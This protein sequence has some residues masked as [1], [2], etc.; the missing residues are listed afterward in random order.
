MRCSGH[1]SSHQSAQSGSNETIQDL[2]SLPALYPVSLDILF[3]FCN[4]LFCSAKFLSNGTIQDPGS[5]V[6]VVGCPVWLCNSDP[7][8]TFQ[9]L[10]SLP[11]P[12]PVWPN[13]L[14]VVP[15][16]DPVGSS[17]ASS[18]QGLCPKLYKC[19]EQSCGIRL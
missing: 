15:V 7:M 9:Y 16:E 6:C 14:F 5:I 4:A 18:S 11:A 1:V 8:K 2:L 12:S 13:I 19:H 10:L 17:E 3:Y